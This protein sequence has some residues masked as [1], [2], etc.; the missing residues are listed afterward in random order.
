MVV[1][2]IILKNGNECSHVSRTIN[3]HLSPNLKM[4]DVVLLRSSLLSLLGSSRSPKFAAALYAVHSSCKAA[5]KL[6]FSWVQVDGERAAEAA[7]QW[8]RSC[9]AS[10]VL[11]QG[12]VYGACCKFFDGI[13]S[14]DA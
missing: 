13:C 14:C 6:R 7:V 4:T 10:V 5:T 12:V 8:L 3:K 2:C 1:P 11:E 9:N